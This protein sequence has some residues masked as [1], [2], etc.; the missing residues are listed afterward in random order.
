MRRSS[1]SVVLNIAEGEG[2]RGGTARARF[3][4]ACGSV[5]EVRASL[6]AAE[7]LGYIEPADEATMD[8]LDRLARTLH[9]LSR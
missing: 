4:N 7:A 3:E 2:S 5:R 8:R 9:K 1:A 6:H